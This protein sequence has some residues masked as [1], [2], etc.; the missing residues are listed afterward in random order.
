[1]TSS[2]HNKYDSTWPGDVGAAVILCTIAQGTTTMRQA[3]SGAQQHSGF[4]ERALTWPG[5]GVG[6]SVTWYTLAQGNTTMRQAA[7][8]A[9]QHSGFGE[10]HT[11]LAGR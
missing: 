4:E 1:M 8:G 10:A 3:T 2:D 7:S 5:G 11:Y 9:Q 6:P